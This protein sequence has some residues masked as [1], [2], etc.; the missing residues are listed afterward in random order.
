MQHRVR[1][2]NKFSEG[3]IAHLAVEKTNFPFRLAASLLETF[4]ACLNT[5]FAIIA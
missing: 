5:F 1:T 2:S 3:S 4:F